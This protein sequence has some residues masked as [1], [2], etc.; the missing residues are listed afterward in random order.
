MRVKTLITV[1]LFILI[2]CIAVV[3]QAELP[4]TSEGD[5]PSVALLNLANKADSGYSK[6]Y[7]VPY[8]ITQYVFEAAADTITS[9]DSLIVILQCSPTGSAAGPWFN[10]ATW[11]CGVQGEVFRQVISGAG[12]YVRCLYQCKGS[13]IANDFRCYLTPKE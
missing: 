10:H 13:G 4:K 9:A 7:K 8:K 11:R 6:T 1:T 12:R 2:G 5:Y 3:A